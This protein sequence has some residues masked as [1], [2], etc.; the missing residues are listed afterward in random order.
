MLQAFAQRLRTAIRSSD[1][2]ARWGGEEFAVLLPAAS[3]A[4][5][6]FVMERFQAS[7]AQH[8]LSGDA[9]VTFSCGLAWLQDAAGIDDALTRADEALYAAKSDGRNRIECARS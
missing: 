6:R 3:L 8:P 1:I 2:C 5:A 4:Q 7:I 9:A